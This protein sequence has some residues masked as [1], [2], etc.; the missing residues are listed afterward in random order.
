VGLFGNRERDEVKGRLDS[1]ESELDKARKE[2]ERERARS[3]ELRKATRGFETER[4]LLKSRLA[5]AEVARDKASE[6]K[7]KADLAWKWLEDRY[8]QATASAETAIKAREDDAAKAADAL[9]EAVRLRSEAGQMRADVEHLRGELEAARRER[10]D[11][12]QRQRQTP[13][14]TPVAS[15]SDDGARFKADIDNLRRRLAETAE[16]LQ[17]ALRKAEHNRRAYL[18][19]QM[20]LDLAEDRLHLLATGKPRPIYETPRDV[21][22]D[23]PV[24]EDVEGYVYADDDAGPASQSEIVDSEPQ[25]Q[26]VDSIQATVT[27][28][29][30]DGRPAA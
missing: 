17:V 18:V 29:V 26:P 2:L 24:P 23:R 30:D 22:G 4:D 5:E 21:A 9:T 15:A 19:T 11:E 7:A 6:L 1:V 10:S 14:P 12:R 20:Q 8:N 28:D 13:Q 16:H 27:S 3:E 25:D